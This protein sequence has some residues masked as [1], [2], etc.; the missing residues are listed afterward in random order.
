MLNGVLML[1]YLSIGFSINL[2]SSEL[3]SW[4]MNTPNGNQ[5]CNEKLNDKYTIGIICKNVKSDANE[6]GHIISNIRKW[7]FYK[8]HIIG[9]SKFENQIRYFIFNENT[10][11]IDIFVQKLDFE[12]ALQKKRLTPLIW[13]RWHKQYWGFIFTDGDFGEGILYIFF[14]LPLFILS[15]LVII[16]GLLKTKCDFRKISTWILALYGCVLLIRV[17]LD[18]YPGSI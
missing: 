18:Y 5:I 11:E 7:F 2:F 1:I 9:E 17:I 3:G 8:K 15:W 16:I 12:S 4:W 6:F 14:K 10:C 13:K